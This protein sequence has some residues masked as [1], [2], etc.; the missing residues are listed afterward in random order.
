MCSKACTLWVNI[1]QAEHKVKVVLDFIS[2]HDILKVAEELSRLR[3]KEVHE[4]RKSILIVAAALAV[5]GCSSARVDDV[6]ADDEY[7]S[8][9]TQAVSEIR[10]GYEAGPDALAQR[11]VAL[12]DQRAF[13]QRQYDRCWIVQDGRLRAKGEAMPQGCAVF[14]RDFSPQTAELNPSW[15]AQE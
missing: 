10:A 11:G 8:A 6:H 3:E 15:F 7:R 1:H 9:T 5:T 12:L 14:W 4:M 13:E 2:I